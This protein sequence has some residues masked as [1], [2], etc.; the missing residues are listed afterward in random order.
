MWY[1]FLAENLTIQNKLQ[2]SHIPK[3]NYSWYTSKEIN[4][5]EKIFS[6]RGNCNGKKKYKQLKCPVEPT[7]TF[8]YSRSTDSPI[9]SPFL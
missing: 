2:D 3:Y 4:Q 9:S 7:S 8:Q 1:V 5:Q 6:I